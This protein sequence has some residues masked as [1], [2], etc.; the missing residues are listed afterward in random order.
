MITS[1]Q[2]LSQSSAPTPQDRIKQQQA[3]ILDRLFKAAS[4]FG[5]LAALAGTI[6][7]LQNQSDNPWII[8]LYWLS[9]AIVLVFTFWK[10]PP[11]SLKA[12]VFVGLLFIL[13]ATDFFDEGL[14]GSSQAFLITSIFAASL[15]LRS[16]SG[17]FILVLSIFTMISFSIA[18]SSGLLIDPNDLRSAKISEWVPGIAVVALSGTLIISSLNQLIPQLISSLRESQSLM[19]ELHDQQATLEHQVQERTQ[20]LE[21][22]IHQLEITAR[23]IQQISAIQQ[24]EPLL[25]QTTQLISDHFGHYHVGIFLLDENRQNAVLRAANSLVGKK[26]ISDGDR[27]RVRDTS[28][29]SAAIENNE[30][31]ISQKIA[32]SLSLGNIKY[33]ET[34]SELALP[35]R[36]EGVLL[37]ALNIHSKETGV[38]SREDAIILQLLAD[39]VALAIDNT[40]LFQQTQ[41]NLTSSQRS[42]DQASLRAWQQYLQKAGELRER[43]D[44]NK[45]LPPNGKM[46]E[47]ST[48]TI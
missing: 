22:R 12:W 8:L 29:I 4:I 21:N 27:V 36:S 5:A 13:G 23:I 43:Y 33:P 35:L 10:K 14:N 37:G 19:D 31:R 3:Q 40:I 32:T 46:T 17:G 47:T 42:F 34:L 44:P 24:L 28:L 39:Q 48:S 25:Q 11:Y 20:N 41:E 16:R 38:F 7:S 1:D 30:A 45:V 6:D 26:H 2:N 9:L 15:L 18:F